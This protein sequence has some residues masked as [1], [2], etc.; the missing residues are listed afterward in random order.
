MELPLSPLSSF[1]TC[2][3]AALDGRALSSLHRIASSAA[4]LSSLLEC[5]VFLIKRIRNDG[6][7]S[8][9]GNSQ[10]E[11][12]SPETIVREQFSRVWVELTTGKLKVEER[13]AARLLAQTLEA[14]YALDQSLLE[15]TW[16]VIVDA[17]K[18]SVLQKENASLVSAVLKVFYD[19]FRKEDNLLKKRGEALMDDVLQLAVGQCEASLTAP[20]AHR[21]MQDNS[22]FALM[23]GILDRFRDGLFTNDAFSN[24]SIPVIVI[25]N[26]RL[27]SALHSVWIYYSLRIVISCSLSVIHFSSLTFFTERTNLEHSPFGIRC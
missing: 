2:F 6:A 23:A 10:L 11:G 13:A 18:A 14:L 3:W 17:L 27:T 19:R 7:R 26:Y 9:E 24:V 5:T 1:F 22:G 21:E 8:N 16:T 25:V 20:V 12:T 4:F 15:V